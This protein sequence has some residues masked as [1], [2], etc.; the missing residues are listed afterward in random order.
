MGAFKHN[1]S[2]CVARPPRTL[3]RLASVLSLALAGTAFA[4][5]GRAARTGRVQKA[6]PAVSTS[7]EF[8]RADGGHGTVRPSHDAPT[9]PALTRAASQQ[10]IET[11]SPLGWLERFGSVE[12]GR[13][14]VPTAPRP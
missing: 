7:P 3:A 11:M 5:D 6:E 14:D 1:L 9:R 13:I 2:R 8:A 10:R 12:V 4:D